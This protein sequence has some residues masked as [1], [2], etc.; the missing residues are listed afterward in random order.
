MKISPKS[1]GGVGVVVGC[2]IKNNK[3]KME[4]KII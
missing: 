4:I 1:W 3:I 2:K